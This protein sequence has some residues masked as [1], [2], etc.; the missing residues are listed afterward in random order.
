MNK[1][2]ELAKLMFLC[3]RTTGLHAAAYFGMLGHLNLLLERGASPSST[4]HSRGMTPLH[5]AAINGHD[6]VCERLLAAGAVA[7][8]KDKRGRTALAY[9]TKLGHEAVRRG[10]LVA[11]RGTSLS[12]GGRDLAAV[13]L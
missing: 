1:L 9:A 7:S 11:G 6:D 12:E 5:L 2:P 10:L 3:S 13:Q 8:T 4:A